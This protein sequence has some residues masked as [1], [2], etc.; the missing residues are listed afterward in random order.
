[1]QSP[2]VSPLN[3][4]E[5]ADSNERNGS[6]KKTRWLWYL[7]AALLIATAC[8]QLWLALSAG[9]SPWSGG[10]FGMFSTLDAG[11]SRH[12]HAI[13]L[14]PGIRR[15][16][17]IPDSLDE[18]VLRALTLPSD[19]RLRTLA[20]AF[21]KLPNPDAGPLTAM[22][23]QVW[24]QSFDARSLSPYGT[25]LRSISIPFDEVSSNEP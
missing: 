19:G 23:I 10:G 15:E 13:A 7:P 22:E 20:L 4:D 12:L 14:R 5:A 18:E 16:L 6:N 3:E 1:M 24:A 11:G 21:A 8:T 17:A 25:L 9:L 2:S